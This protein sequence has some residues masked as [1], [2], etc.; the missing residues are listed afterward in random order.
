MKLKLPYLMLLC[1]LFINAQTIT[2]FSSGYTSLE[3][4]AI[5][6]NNEVF[7]SEN[8]SGTNDMVFDQDNNLFIAE[9]FTS[10]IFKV[11]PAGLINSNY[12]SLSSSS[13]YGIAIYNGAL[14]FSGENSANVT[15]VNSDLT[16]E[17]YANGFFTPEGIAFDSDGNLYVADRNDRKLFKI[18][19]NGV[20]TTLATS[21]RNI[22]GVAVSPA[23]DVYFTT[24]NTLPE[25]NKIQKYDPATGMISD[26]VSTNLNQPRS[27]EIDRLGNMYVT[28]IG[29]GTVVKIYDDSLLP[30]ST[31]DPIVNIPDANFKAALIANQ[32]IN[33][34]ADAEIQV[35]EAEVFSGT[36]SVD[37][38][39]IADLTGI[40]AFIELTRLSCSGNQLLTLDLS[41][42]VNLTALFASDNLLT[43]IN[44]TG[45]TVLEKFWAQRNMITSLDLSTNTQITELLCSNNELTTLDVSNNTAAKFIYFERNDISTIDFSN[46]L[47]VEYIRVT[48]NNLPNLDV[49]AN[50]NLKVLYCGQNDLTNL[51]VTTNSNL[52]ELEFSFNSISTIDLSNNTLLE[53]LGCQSVD[54]VNIDLSLNTVLERLL[55]GGPL[56]SIDLT[57]NLLLQR[58]IVFG[59]MDTIDV[60][61]NTVLEEITISSQNL[62]TADLRN[63]NNVNLTEVLFLTVPNLTCVYV[64]DKTY[65]EANWTNPN[66]GLTNFVETEQECNTILSVNNV[67]TISFNV[68]P[69]PATSFLNIKTT[70][71]IKEAVIYNLLG[72]ELLIISASQINISDLAKGMYLLSIKGENNAVTTKSFVK[73]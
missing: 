66:P 26:F 60:S 50:T 57:N 72:K 36:I 21:I 3:G 22:R 52:T 13:P 12:F 25:E 15:K 58:L 42:N 29:S 40:E 45:L 51:D 64:D 49:S 34:N 33:T 70:T 62:T 55:I 14:Y 18:T 35:S 43:G 28:N 16:S 53:R 39:N 8:N 6:S 48:G 4:V 68:Y 24:Y 47:D 67:E 27:L 37:D 7:V 65:S 59:A 19:Q 73:K 30:V 38:R 20:K 71:T 1:S 44:T 23:N 61:N 10:R 17:A 41:S 31:T 32:A 5:N 69:N 46:N 56:A 11:E 63:G 2:E 9:P 54:I